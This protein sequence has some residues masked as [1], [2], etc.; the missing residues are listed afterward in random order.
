MVN[1]SA[2]PTGVLK[3]MRDDM[4]ASCSGV[5]IF[6][7]TAVTKRARHVQWEPA[8]L[9]AEQ[10]SA[11]SLFWAEGR[12]SRENRIDRWQRLVDEF[13]EQDPRSTPILRAV[14]KFREQVVFT[15]RD[16]VGGAFRRPDGSIGLF[17]YATV[18]PDP[19]V[20]VSERELYKRAMSE[21]DEHGLGVVR[22]GYADGSVTAVSLNG[23]RVTVLRSEVG[24]ISFSGQPIPSEGIPILVHGG[25]GIASPEVFAGLLKENPLLPAPGPGGRVV[26]EPRFPIDQGSF[27]VIHDA[28]APR[29]YAAV[30]SESRLRRAD[31]SVE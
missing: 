15:P 31:S 7:A 3:R 2:V 19:W 5:A 26:L 27:R 17:S 21:R 20:H 29:G 13:R 23:E 28:L 4:M 9:S 8:E 11:R 6:Y 25:E 1:V 18:N 12:Y 22:P 10:R 30:I 24:A 14:S 16:V